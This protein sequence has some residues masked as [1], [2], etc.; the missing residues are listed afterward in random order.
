[1]IK[2][3][4]LQRGVGEAEIRV[5]VI[6]SYVVCGTYENWDYQVLSPFLF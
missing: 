5:I 6:F 1:L 3:E 2:N 4:K